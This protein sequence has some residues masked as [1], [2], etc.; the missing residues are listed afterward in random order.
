M[1]LSRGRILIKVPIRIEP[2]EGGYHAYSPALPGCRVGGLTPE[3]ARG[4]L[5]E[6]IRLHLASIIKRDEP[7]PEGC[8]IAE[9]RDSAVQ[10][11]TDMDL[12]PEVANLAA[13]S[14]QKV[15]DEVLIHV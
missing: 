3:E 14:E 12:L 6:A 2:D 11:I 9:I 4:H 13:N 8:I 10:Q 5:V 1:S 15:A 7:I